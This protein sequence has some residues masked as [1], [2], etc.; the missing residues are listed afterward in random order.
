MTFRC[1]DRFRP[2]FS[3]CQVVVSV[4]DTTAPTC[5]LTAFNDHIVQ[6]T[7]R[8]TGSGLAAINVIGVVHSVDLEPIVFDV[9]TTDPV[10]IS[11]HRRNPNW[12]PFIHLEI[13]D[14]AGNSIHCILEGQ[15]LRI[16][17]D[18]NNAD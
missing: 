3:Q 7:V 18:G 15:H 9:G 12:A 2:A 14:V 11:A 10:V 13:I 6:I 1:T 8:D 5:E 16:V 17:E 4:A